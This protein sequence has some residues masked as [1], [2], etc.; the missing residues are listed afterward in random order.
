LIDLVNNNNKLNIINLKYNC[1]SNKC[2]NIENIVFVN[3]DKGLT[4][5]II[6]SIFKLSP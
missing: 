3:K 2:G 1:C 4:G 6:V 5:E